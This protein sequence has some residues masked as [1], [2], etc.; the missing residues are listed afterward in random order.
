MSDTTTGIV[1]FDYGIWTSIYPAFA[2]TTSQAQAQN[3][4]DIACL[5]I[6]NTPTSPI[7]VVDCVGNQVRA[8][9]LGLTTA[10]ICIKLT[11]G[12]PETVGRVASANQG[13]VSLTLDMGT[14]PANAAWWQQTQ[15]GTMAWRALAPYRSFRYFPARRPYLGVGMLGGGAPGAAGGLAGTSYKGYFPWLS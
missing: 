6:N 4:F 8:K 1:V 13:S 5:Y 15:Y 3:Y 11:P 2:S 7:P 10:H 9:I 14:T 12:A